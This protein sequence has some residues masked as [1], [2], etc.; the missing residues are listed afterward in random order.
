MKYPTIKELVK[1]KR[2]NFDF[3]RANVA[4]YTT[5]DNEGFDWRFPVRLDDVGDATLLAQDK[6]ILYMRW[7]RKAITNNELHKI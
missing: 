4:Y 2:V 1:D 3:Y 6:A 5:T 7:I